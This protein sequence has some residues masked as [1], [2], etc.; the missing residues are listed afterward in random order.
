MIGCNVKLKRPA[1]G[2]PAVGPGVG[3]A[4]RANGGPSFQENCA[5]YAAGIDQLQ[6]CCHYL[7]AGGPVA[8]LTRRGTGRRM[9]PAGVWSRQ[10]R[11]RKAL[12]KKRKGP[13][14][15]HPVLCSFHV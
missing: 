3:G 6:G 8:L 10:E 4:G 14:K 15:I 12:Q 13:F 7:N 9:D 2:D 5:A 1:A 11:R